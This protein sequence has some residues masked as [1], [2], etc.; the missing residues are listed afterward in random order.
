MR[1]VLTKAASI[2]PGFIVNLLEEIPIYFAHRNSQISWCACFNCSEMET[3]EERVC[4]GKQNC[5][6]P[7]PVSFRFFYLEFE[8]QYL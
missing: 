7:Q 2:Q 8:R 5:F 3:D 6:S 4:C 1:D